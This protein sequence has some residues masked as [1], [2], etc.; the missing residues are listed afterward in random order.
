MSR[1]E[2]AATLFRMAPGRWFDANGLM[3]VLGRYAWRT[4][5]S[6]CRKPPYNLRIENK[7]VRQPWG[8][9]SMYRYQPD[10]W[11]DTGIGV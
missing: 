5:I 8:V 1:T 2:L 11:T 10:G 9:Q 4:R 3:S 6:E 7:Q